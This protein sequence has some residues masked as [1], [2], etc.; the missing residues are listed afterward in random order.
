MRTADTT[1]VRLAL[2]RRSGSWSSSD[3]PR[4]R[5]RLLVVAACVAACSTAR[6]SPIDGRGRAAPTPPATATPAPAT[7]PDP[8]ASLGRVGGWQ[9]DIAAIVPGLERIHPNPF[10][11]TPKAD[12]EAA[13]GRALGGGGDTR[14]TTSSWSACRASSRMVSAAGCDAH[15]GVFMWGTGTYPVESLPLRLWLFGD[16]V[17]IVDALPPYQDLIGARIDT[18]EGHPIADVL[19]AIDPL[20]PRDNDQTVRLLTPR[21][22][23]IPQVLRGIGLAERRRDPVGLT[24]AAAARRRSMSADPDGRLQQLGRAVRAAPAAPTPTSATCRGSTTTCGGSCSP[25]ARRCTSSTTGSIEC[26]RP[27]SATSSDALKAPEVTPRRP[28]PPAQ[29]RRRGPAARHHG[30]A[31]RR[32]GGRPARRAVR[33][34]GP[35]HVLR[36]EHARGPARGPD[37]GARSSASRWAAARR[38]G[39]TSRA[40]LVHSGLSVLIRRRRRGRRRPERHALERSSPTPGRAHAGGVGRP[41]GPGAG[42]L[43]PRRSAP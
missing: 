19:A 27:A 25:T 26:R 17:V 3:A 38:S 20:I 5:R 42:L 9:A 39:A 8:A 22:L 34:H 18:I 6:A 30:R 33:D 11:G 37:G 31:V 35:Q 12:I 29:L 40:P 41:G 43:D 16:E 7:A 13:V 10:H 36:G 23:L 24:D 21:Y 4:L 1:G 2:A 32:P 14:P 28:R 15:T